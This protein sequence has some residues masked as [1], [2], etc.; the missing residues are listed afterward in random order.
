MKIIKELANDIRDELHGAEHYAKLAIRY[1]DEDRG[2]SDTY[3]KLSE[4]EMSH[5][6]TLHDQ[7]VRIIRDRKEKM[8]DKV[9]A[10]MQAV[11]DWE[12]E[13]MLDDMARV[14]IMLDLY[15]K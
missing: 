7:A 9:P 15:R 10:G 5:A 14:R 1:K 12:H 3:A 8:Q 11:W 4:V 6:V 2:L 13:K